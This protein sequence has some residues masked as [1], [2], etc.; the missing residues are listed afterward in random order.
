[1]IIDCHCHAGKGDGL[2]S[3]LG[4]V[5]PLAS[6]LRRA[7]AAGIGL[8][9]LLP[10]F[11]RDYAAANRDVSDLVRGSCE[12][13]TGFA[14]LHP[15]RDAGAV[16]EIVR[17]AVVE[18]GFVGIK[19]HR[20]DAP[21]SD[22]ICEAARELA[23][24]VLYDIV[25]KVRDVERLGRMYPEVDFI[26]PHLGSYADDWRA[27]TRLIDYLVAFPNLYTDT[28]GVR[29]FDV[30]ERAIRS[31]GPTKVLF[32]SDG[33]WCHPAVELAKVRHLRLPSPAERLVL[34]GNFLRLVNIAPRAVDLP[35]MRALGSVP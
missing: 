5:L 23:L 14:L 29:R 20:V 9:N 33:P 10:S 12:R 35:A 8:V 27:Q 30:L 24:P 6:F 18:Q 21:I 11:Q 2:T 28:S 25:G 16:Y 3:P 1:M 19:V 17:R 31:A 34:G 22:E 32:G 4:T 13:L 7:R 15:V 26:I